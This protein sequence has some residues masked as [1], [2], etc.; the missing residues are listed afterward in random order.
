MADQNDFWV[1]FKYIWFE[2]FS[3]A[4]LRFVEA[5]GCIY[6]IVWSLTLDLLKLQVVFVKLSAAQYRI[7]QSLRSYLWNCL[8][9]PCYRKI[10]KF[11][12][13]FNT[14]ALTMVGVL[15]AI[16]YLSEEASQDTLVIWFSPE[17]NFEAFKTHFSF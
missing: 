13:Y 9:V 11:K 15:M 3:Y 2:I 4:W 6:Q 16:Y 17:V 7:S 8:D 12:T 14:S 10:W 1:S 5:V